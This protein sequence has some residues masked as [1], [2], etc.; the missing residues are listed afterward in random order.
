VDLEAAT[1]LLGSLLHG[2][3]PEVPCA[4]LS[5]IRIEPGTVVGDL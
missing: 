4:Q 5:S 3:Q 2:G 1:E